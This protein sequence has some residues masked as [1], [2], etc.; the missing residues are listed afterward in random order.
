MINN[1]DK[2]QVS[3][4]ILSICKGS[5]NIIC[6]SVVYN[7]KELIVTNDKN[8]NN[9]YKKGYCLI[10]RYN[11][12]PTNKFIELKDIESEVFEYDF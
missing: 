1:R 9:Y 4:K 11:Y 2:R 5:K 8:I 3:R 6:L 7:G 10:G 12:L